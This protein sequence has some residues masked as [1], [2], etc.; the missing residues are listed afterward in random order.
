MEISTNLYRPTSHTR[1][2]AP[3]TYLSSV[4]KPHERQL[5]TSNHNKPGKPS[6]ASSHTRKYDK[7]N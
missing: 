7:E 5:A 6:I 2:Q 3:Q 4:L 1:I